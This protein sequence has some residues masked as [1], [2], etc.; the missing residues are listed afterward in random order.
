MKI[1][2]ASSAKREAQAEVLSTLLKIPKEKLSDLKS[3]IK[4]KFAE[5]MR[6]RNNFIFFVDALNLDGRYKDN[7]DRTKDYRLKIRSDYQDIYFKALENGEGYNPM[8]ALEKVFKAEGLDKKEPELYKKIV[9]YKKILEEPQKN[10]LIKRIL[11]GS[12]A[13]LAICFVT[14][15]AVKYHSHKKEKPAEKQ[16][17]GF[18]R[19]QDKF[20]NIQHY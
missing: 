16:P 1:D 3:F 6:A 4:A 2:F 18:I 13:A 5:P 20:A 7:T 10:I 14:L 17:A 19:S 8:D 15:A 11:T 9:K 12:A